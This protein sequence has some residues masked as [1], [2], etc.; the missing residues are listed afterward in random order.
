VKLTVGGRSIHVSESGSGPPVILVH[1][2][3]LTSGQWA[4]YTPRLAG[5]HRVLAPDLLGYGR[6]DPWPD[7]DRFALAEDAAIVGALLAE[8]GGAHLVGHSYGGLVAL[9]AAKDAPSLV[10]SIALYEPV[11]FGVLHSSGHAA[12]IAD[13]ATEDFF[14]DAS[15]GG[16]E[17]WMRAFIEYWNGAGAFD[18]LPPARRAP[19]LAAGR[20]TFLEVR[21]LLTDRTPHLA[22]RVIDAPAL[23]LRGT[24]SPVAGRAVAEILAATLPRARL[25]TLDGAGHM[26]PVLETDRVS[27]RIV[28]FIAAVGK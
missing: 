23:L 10:R 22:Y 26:A 1:A 16:D 19:I 2:S 11:A 27:L 20:K 14:L 7:P 12:G 5:R 24:T 9:L 18:A 25:E 28:E 6:S 21:E 13:L 8:T 17:R 15:A 3:T 4:R